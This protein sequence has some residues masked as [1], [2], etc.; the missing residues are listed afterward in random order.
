MVEE[1]S[2]KGEELWERR[3]L[4]GG[5]KDMRRDRGDKV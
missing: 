1:V 5:H 2:E 4:R 3:G